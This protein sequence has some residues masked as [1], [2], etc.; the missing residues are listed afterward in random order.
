MGLCLLRHAALQADHDWQ[1]LRERD[2]PGFHNTIQLV[3]SS[4]SSVRVIA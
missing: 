4:Q 2:A 1:W 3:S